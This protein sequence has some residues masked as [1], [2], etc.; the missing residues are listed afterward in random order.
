[1]PNDIATQVDD[2]AKA[3]L[4]S[5]DHCNSC[6]KLVLNPKELANFIILFWDKFDDKTGEPIVRDAV[7]DEKGTIA[8]LKACV[9][10][11]QKIKK[12]HKR[13]T[14]SRSNQ[15]AHLNDGPLKKMLTEI[16]P[17]RQASWKFEIGWMILLPILQKLKANK[18]RALAGSEG[19]N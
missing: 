15:L 13:Y 8:V 3:H 19:M 14:F 9:S 6:N 18:Q 5:K 2:A 4:V 12:L 1:M 17:R 16:W 11:G 10:C 7:F